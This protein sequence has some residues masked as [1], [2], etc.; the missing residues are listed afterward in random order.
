MEEPQ[1]LGWGWVLSEPQEWTEIAE[2]FLVI[3]CILQVESEAQNQSVSTQ[4]PEAML[5]T[6]ED[7]RVICLLRDLMQ[8]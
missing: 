6:A 7:F 3:K 2:A 4:G 8:L 1:T 5:P